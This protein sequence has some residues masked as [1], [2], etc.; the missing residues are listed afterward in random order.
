MALANTPALDLSC[1]DINSNIRSTVSWEF[2]SGT[3][4]HLKTY[5]TPHTGRYFERVKM[6]KSCT[7]SPTYFDMY[8][9]VSSREDQI[10]KSHRA[11]SIML[12]EN[13]VTRWK[14][15][16]KSIWDTFVEGWSK[17]LFCRVW[18]SRMAKERD[19]E[20]WKSTI[21]GGV[22]LNDTSWPT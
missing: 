8:R 4:D 10:S 17:T 18:N 12:I 1:V 14:N 16:G 5:R 20:A 11:Q 21:F 6:W 19:V 2:S 9:C 7:V 15:L 22:H 3:V 13:H